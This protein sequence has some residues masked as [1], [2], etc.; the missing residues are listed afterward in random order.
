MAS[1]VTEWADEEPITQVA[2]AAQIDQPSSFTESDDWR[3]PILAF[4]RTGETPSNPDQVRLLKR[5]PRFTIIGDQLYRRAFSWPLL[6]CLGPEDADY[7]M[8]EA[9]QGCCSNH[10]GGRSLARKILLAGYFWPTLQADSAKLVSTCI[11]CQKY[12][13]FSKHPTK[14]LRAA[15]ISC[16][17]D[18]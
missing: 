14:Q 11:H 1:S 15:T 10:P 6:K 2:L 7:V 16:P 5:A 9:H 3:T 4:L 18:Q 17:F 12:Q 13:P 8:R